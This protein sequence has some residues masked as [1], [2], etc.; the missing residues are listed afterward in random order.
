MNTD[1]WDG[2]DRRGSA[3]QTITLTADIVAA[4]VSNNS[5][6]VNDLPQLIANVHGALT[7][8]AGPAPAAK[9]EP[10][11]PI[12]S[13]IKPDYIVCLEDGK[14]LKMLKRHLMTHYQMTPD[15]YRTKWLAS[16]LSNGGTELRRTASRTGALDRA[17]KE[18]QGSPEQQEEEDSLTRP[19]GG[20]Y[21][22]TSARCRPLMA[23]S[24]RP[25]SAEP[26][27]LDTARPVGAL[28]LW[29]K[30]PAPVER[31]TQGRGGRCHRRLVLLLV[32]V[33]AWPARLMKN[34]ARRSRSCAATRCR[35][36]S[37]LTSS[38][39]IASLAGR[40][41]FAVRYRLPRRRRTEV[42]IVP[43]LPS[44]VF[45]PFPQVDCALDLGLSGKVPRAWP[46]LFD[47]RRPQLKEDQL[48]GLKQIEA[49]KADPRA[50]LVSFSPGQAVRVVYGPLQGHNGT[51]V[52]R[53]GRDRWVIQIDGGRQ[54]SVPGF[55]V[56]P[57]GIIK[58]TG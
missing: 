14:K 48:Q 12:R 26:E 16:R 15:Q 9:L 57:A 5:V 44:F 43:L 25:P 40:L 28:P 52:C 36:S 3:E 38:S 13:S 51:V 8:L 35:R 32:N 27:G 2:V 37:W 23:P 18:G 34:K 22:K 42:R 49:R 58:A 30:G 54:V 55:L 4:H 17:R 46:F 29:W 41:E 1:E 6:A 47:G 39:T 19:A 24:K 7:G 21:C 50:P 33:G 10:K 31:L 56:Q 20:D 53:K 11:V 45:V